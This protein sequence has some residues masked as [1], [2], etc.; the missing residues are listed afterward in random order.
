MTVNIV[1]PVLDEERR[2]RSGI[3]KTEAFLQ[4]NPKISATIT[5]VDNGSTDR[6]LEIIEELAAEYSNI[7]YISLS[8]KGFG[9]AFR[10]AVK[11][12]TCDIIGYVDCDLSTDIHYLKTILW[13]FQNDPSYHIIKGNRLA[14]NAHVHGRKLGRNITSQGL[15]WMIKLFFGVKVSDTMEGF[16]FFRRGCIEDLLTVSS[17]DNGWFYCAELLIRAEKLGYKIG[18]LPVVW[19]DDYDTKVNVK[20]L[21][22]NYV[23]RMVSLKWDLI[24]EK[25]GGV[26]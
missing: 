11:L 17:E 13:Y 18:E 19:N 26:R 2:L 25:L 23:T 14:P 12:N 3:E 6:T 20:K 15:N 16:Q 1:F 7:D 10:E 24:R 22:A 21:I 5:I 4:A 8:E 9:L